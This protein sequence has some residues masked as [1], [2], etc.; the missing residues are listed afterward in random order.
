MELIDFGIVTVI[1]HEKDAMI[2][3]LEG[4]RRVRGVPP[5]IRDYYRGYLALADASVYEFVLVQCAQ[6]GNSDAGQAAKDLIHRWNPR[7]LIILGVAGGYPRGDIKI[8]DVVI[9]SEIVEYDYKK[10]YHNDWLPR[11]RHHQ[12]DATL[13]AKITSL[14]EWIG[15]DVP[16]PPGEKK[17]NWKPKLQK[18]GPIAAGNALFASKG[19]RDRLLSLQ[20]DLLAVEMESEGVAV[21]AWQRNPPIPVFVIRGICDLADAST[22]GEDDDISEGDRFKSEDIKEKRQITAAYSAAS[23][24]IHFLSDRPIESLTICSNDNSKLKR[25]SVGK[26]RSKEGRR[27]KSKPRSTIK[28]RI[29]VKESEKK[30]E[31]RVNEKD[32]SILV[33]I[34][35]GFFTMGSSPSMLSTGGYTENTDVPSESIPHI[36][37]IGG[38]WIGKFPIT[39]SQYK[40]FIKETGYREPDRWDDINFNGPNQP[41][42]GLSLKDTQAY[43]S[44]AGLRLP[45]EAE[46]QYVACGPGMNPRIFPWGNE[47]PTSTHLNYMRLNRGTTN[48][49]QYSL[50]TTPQTEL[51]DMV[52]NVL[53]WCFDD[54]RDYLPTEISNPIGDTKGDYRAIRGGSF[55][56]PANS[57]RSAYRDRR[58]INSR[59]G[60]TGFR[61]ALGGA[62]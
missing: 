2:K 17:E 32:G 15:F 25:K 11:P 21:A 9:A 8:G 45:T 41:V 42:I 47:Y 24:L 3:R 54:T 43:L 56:R 37:Q 14:S 18:S 5:D 31:T 27:K 7:Y 33:F 20:Q 50:G 13:L 1:K 61:P 53:E 52:G 49:S 6:S 38:F 29:I 48:V 26:N 39:N 36:V 12:T 58:N 28:P 16:T 30:I 46:W 4:V 62:F 55:A 22:K 10:F 51:F 60:S 59:W 44:W 35:S 34:E 23:F 19:A 40:R 57:C